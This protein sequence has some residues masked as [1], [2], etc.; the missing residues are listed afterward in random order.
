MTAIWKKPK[1]FLIDFWA[2]YPHKCG[3]MQ[4][5]NQ[6]IATENIFTHSFTYLFMEWTHIHRALFSKIR[7]WYKGLNQY[8]LSFYWVSTWQT[9]TLGFPNTP[10]ILL[11]SLCPFIP[12]YNHLLNRYLM[13]TSYVWV[14]VL[15]NGCIVVPKLDILSV[16]SLKSLH[17]SWRRKVISKTVNKI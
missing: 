15:G 17:F 3:R 5:K 1:A 2:K 14:T 9:Y 8:L 10:N 13:S 16:V 11:C 6:Q 7:R 4:R 12:S